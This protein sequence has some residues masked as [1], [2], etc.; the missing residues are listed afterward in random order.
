MWLGALGAFTFVAIM[1]MPNR[2]IYASAPRSLGRVIRVSALAYG[3]AT[4]TYLLLAPR[5]D[6]VAGI[7]IAL[8]ALLS[9]IV[10]CAGVVAAR[11]G[12][13]RGGF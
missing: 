13:A 3:L 8:V 4:A 5:L 9:A 12:G 10:M 11:H 7:A 6:G 1:A 2:P